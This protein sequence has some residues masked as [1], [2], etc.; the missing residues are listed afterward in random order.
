MANQPGKDNIETLMAFIEPTADPIL[1]P[2]SALA[3]GTLPTE[4]PAVA[5]ALWNDMNTVKVSAGA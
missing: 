4:D 3:L 2:L 5:G 1:T